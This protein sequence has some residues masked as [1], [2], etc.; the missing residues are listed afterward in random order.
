MVRFLFRFAPTEA[1]S[2]APRKD[3]RVE[4]RGR[5]TEAERGARARTKTAFLYTIK[6]ILNAAEGKGEGGREGG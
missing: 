5:G 2:C 3:K 4:K 6:S 1:F